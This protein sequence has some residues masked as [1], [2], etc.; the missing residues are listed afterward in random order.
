[1]NRFIQIVKNDFKN[2]LRYSVL[3][4][5][6]IIS[7]LFSV[8]MA[9]FPQ[10]NP[11]ILVY[12]TVFIIPV[13]ILSISIYIENEEKTLFPLAMC[14]CSSLEI[15]LAKLVS[16]LLMLLIPMVLYII[17]MF[18]VLHMNFS[19]ILFIL[20][21]LLS[22]ITHII[23]GIVLAIISKSSHIMSISYIGYIVIF[24]VMPIFYQEGLI[25]EFFQYILIVSPAYLSGILFEQI[26]IGYIHTADWLIIIAVLLQ[27]VYI[28]VFTMFVIRPYFKSYLFYRISE[29][30]D[31][32]E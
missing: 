23:I 10:I 31:Q 19:I 18:T 4:T 6:L 9:F 2:Y 21:Y 5:V 8:T 24:S 27:F 22:A 25:P 1:L 14:E 13:I 11:L 16:S 3:Q 26:I 20:I 28:G 15:I 12:I 32:L 7:V 17:I 29:K 30:G